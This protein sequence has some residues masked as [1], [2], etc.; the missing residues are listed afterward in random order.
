MIKD[1]IVAAYQSV[2]IDFVTACQFATEFLRELQHEP[3][4]TVWYLGNASRGAILAVR[5][6]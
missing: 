2:G 6:D 5:K 3:S 4:G 1:Q